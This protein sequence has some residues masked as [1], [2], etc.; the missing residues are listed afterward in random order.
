MKLGAIS[1]MTDYSI[2]P[3]EFAMALEANGFD[4]FWAGD[5]THIPVD[6]N[7]SGPTM[8]PRFAR[9]NVATRRV[10]EEMIVAQEPLP[11]MPDELKALFEEKS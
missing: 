2:A 5:H 6:P 11:E 4:S 1:F 10:G 3:D 8:D 7:V 9:V